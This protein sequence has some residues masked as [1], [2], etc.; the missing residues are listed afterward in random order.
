MILNTTTQFNMRVLLVELMTL[1]VF[2]NY[3][4]SKSNLSTLKLFNCDNRFVANITFFK[5][6]ILESSKLLLLLPDS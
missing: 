2:G 5:Y 3:P 1:I 4:D 6:F